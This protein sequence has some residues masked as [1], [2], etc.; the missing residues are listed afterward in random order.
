MPLSLLPVPRLNRLILK[1][2]YHMPAWGYEISPCVLLL[3]SFFFYNSWVQRTSEMFSRN[4]R[5]EKL[6]ISKRP[7]NFLPITKTQLMKCQSVSLY[8]ILLLPFLN[9]FST[10]GAM[11]CNHINAFLVRVKQESSLGVKICFFVVLT[12][13]LFVSNI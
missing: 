13:Y 11:S 9:D 3:L 7:C 8:V 1:R 6:L 12:L 10:K 2:R 4:R 5:E